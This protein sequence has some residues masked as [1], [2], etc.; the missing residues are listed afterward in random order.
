VLPNEIYPK[1]FLKLF[2]KHRNEVEY[3]V[4]DK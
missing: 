4:F 3:L 1:F 2:E